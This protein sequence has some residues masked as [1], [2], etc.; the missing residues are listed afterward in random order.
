MKTLIAALIAVPLTSGALLAETSDRAGFMPA[1]AQAEEPREPVRRATVQPATLGQAQ[2]APAG[3]ADVDTNGDGRVS[4]D[5]LL[6]HDV[7]TDF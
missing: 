2:L 1:T 5:E 6:R 7:N 4:F 3:L